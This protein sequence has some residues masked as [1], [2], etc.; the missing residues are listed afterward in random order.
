MS[1]R[2]RGPAGPV[3]FAVEKQV[4]AGVDDSVQ[5]ELA[6]QH[7]GDRQIPVRAPASPG[8]HQD[9]MSTGLPTGT[10]RSCRR[11]SSCSR[12][13]P[14]EM[15]APVVPIWAVGPQGTVDGDH[16]VAG[17]LPVGDGVGVRR[18]DDHEG[19]VAG[20]RGRGQEGHEVLARPGW[21]RPDVPMPAGDGQ[22]PICRRGR[23]SGGS[24]A[25]SI[26]I[27]YGVVARVTSVAST[28]AVDSL[29]RCAKRTS[30]QPGR[31]AMT[32]RVEGAVCQVAGTV[33]SSRSA[34]V[35]GNW[36]WHRGWW[37]PA[38]SRPER[39]ERSLADWWCRWS[40]QRWPPLV[41]FGGLRRDARPCPQEANST[42]DADG[43]EQLAVPVP[44]PGST[45]KR[46]RGHV[47]RPGG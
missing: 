17:A 42:A 47:V 6:N 31:P 23:A 45:E 28:Q 1:L 39:A 33:P 8:S 15:A 21:G 43:G 38:S 9:T 14:W 5:D 40:G 4:V 27:P 32:G 19:A 12:M 29:G 25:R 7:V 16:G 30:S 2:A 11:S 34:R 44:G 46:S 3:A 20:A 18:G 10:G 24:C 26:T 41:A 36:G 37:P 22:E 13:Q 35:G